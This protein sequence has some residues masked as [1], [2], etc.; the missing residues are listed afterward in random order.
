MVVGRLFSRPDVI[1]IVDCGNIFTDSKVC[2]IRSGRHLSMCS[3]DR[4]WPILMCFVTSKTVKIIQRGIFLIEVAV[5]WDLEPLGMTCCIC[6]LSPARIRHLLKNG[7]CDHVE[8]RR[9]RTS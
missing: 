3:R 7:C 5:I 8:Y 1:H 4:Y 9:V 6:L 2:D